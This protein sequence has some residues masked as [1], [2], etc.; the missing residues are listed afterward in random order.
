MGNQWYMYFALVRNVMNQS[1][2]TVIFYRTLFYLGGHISANTEHIQLVFNIWLL[3]LKFKLRDS[4]N[5]F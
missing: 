5:R 3:F 1:K 2:I 4:K